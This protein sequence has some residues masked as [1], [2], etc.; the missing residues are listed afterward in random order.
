MNFNKNKQGVSLIV[1]VITI[2]VMIILATT[3]ILSLNSSN[4][5]EKANEAKYKNDL[6]ILKEKISYM[7]NMEML[8]EDSDYDSLIMDSL[9]DYVKFYDGTI[10]AYHG[11]PSKPQAE[12]S[13]E[14]GISVIGENL[15]HNNKSLD[16]L[17]SL[18][19]R[20]VSEGKSK[21]NPNLLT[22]QY[23]RKDRYS[24]GSW[25]MLAGSIDNNFVTY[26]NN[27]KENTVSFSDI[28]D[29]VTGKTID[30]VHAMA[31]I[32]VYKKAT[33]NM[34]QEYACW[35]GDLCTLAVQV[36]NYASSGQYTLD[37]LIEYS[38]KLLGSEESTSSFG[39]SD[40]L[41]DVD[42][43]NI[44]NIMNDTISLE[45]AVYDYY[46]GSSIEVCENRYQYFKDYLE[47]TLY[48]GGEV[49]KVE[50]NDKIYDVALSYTGAQ[51]GALE[52]Q[53]FAGALL[54]Y[55]V[56]EKITWNVWQAVARSFS[57]YINERV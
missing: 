11:D 43:V 26:V 22:L 7:E 53:T 17:M 24:S 40:M 14:M 19:N 29:P 27:N 37:E 8:G 9:K 15:Y 28:I 35:A 36:N 41:A 55:D 18:A 2:I 54:G 45:K 48:P 25:Q 4:T 12:W 33:W 1:L 47:N 6:A 39:L 21:V 51:R 23:I 44:K 16:E 31:S 57:D 20:Y 5:V 56:Y 10:L 52:G 50:G 42:A 13:K 49:Q 3:I 32:N 46:V 38:K 30:F 34:L